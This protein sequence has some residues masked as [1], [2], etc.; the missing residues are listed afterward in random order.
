M[1]KPEVK[2]AVYEYMD[3]I[4]SARIISGWDITTDIHI[5]YGLHSYPTVIL[6]IAKFWA[7]LSG[8]SFECINN[9]T[10]LY[11]FVPGVRKVHGT[12]F[13]SLPVQSKVKEYRRE[14]ALQN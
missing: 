3:G 5:L 12:S 8:G 7:V 10:S 9:H 6:K 2:K 1:I 14:R 13:E 11:S 4:K